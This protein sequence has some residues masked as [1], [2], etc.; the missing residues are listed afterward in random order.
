MNFSSI[1]NN[2]QSRIQQFSFDPEGDTED[3]EE[4]ELRVTTNTKNLGHNNGI[5]STAFSGF[6]VFDDEET[7]EEEL[8]DTEEEFPDDPVPVMRNQVGQV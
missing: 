3:L 5:Q 2:A 7:G 4:L 6:I 1:V 8:S